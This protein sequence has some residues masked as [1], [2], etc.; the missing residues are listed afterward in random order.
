MT[1]LLI[2]IPDKLTSNVTID[3]EDVWF[4]ETMQT[5]DWPRL[6][7][8]LAPFIS[9]TDRYTLL[10]ISGT[11]GVSPALLLT[12]AI[13]YKNE[14]RTSFKCHIESMSAR[15]ME[16][17]FNST[18][19][20]SDQKNKEND[21]THAISLFVENDPK[22]MNELLSIFKTVK[23]EAE[24]FK[25]SDHDFTPDIRHIERGTGDET[26]LRLPFKLSEC[27][28][29]SATHHS[30][31][32]CY[33]RSCPKSSIDLAPSL[34]M[35]FGHDFRY[36]E[37]QGEVMAS[38]SGT[39]YIHSPCKLQVK[40]RR[41]TTFYSHITINR[42]SGEYVR[43]GD[44]LGFIELQREA[45][46]CNCEVDAGRTECSTGPHLH[47]EVRD[48]A[49]KPMDLDGLEVSGFQIHTGSESYDFEC[50]PE[51]CH[52]NMTL[53]EIKESCSTVFLRTADNQTFCPS[54]QGANWG[55]IS[56]N[57]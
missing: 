45:A 44:R 1:F 49:N 5:I 50:G 35:G 53:A 34:F 41:F 48:H 13:Y 26:T 24:H 2:Y 22:Q 55:K 56:L 10:E 14:K 28:M 27:W 12:T 20:T 54:V 8:E 33:S 19:R 31:E 51:N 57:H 11:D 4:G 38:H 43:A 9:Y 18:S 29:L 32:Q 23:T 17:F 42:S 7:K 21:A 36:F 39:V 3:D 15:L 47:W 52:N 16:A 30:N 40:S 46:N 25:D 6:C 37:S